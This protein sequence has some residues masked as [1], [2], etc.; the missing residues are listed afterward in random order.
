ADGSG[1]ITCLINTNQAIVAKYLYDPFGNILSQ[2][3]A[4]ADANLYRFASKEYHKNSG[5]IY[6][7]YR[8]YEPNFARWVNRDPLGE[9]GFTTL[10]RH[11]GFRKAHMALR[12][13]EIAQGPNVYAFVGN[14]P[15]NRFDRFGLKYDSE[16]CAGIL[17]EIDFL[18]SLKGRVGI[19]D[20]SVQQQIN[21]LQDEYDENCG[22]DDNDPRPTPPLVPVPVCPV[23][24]P[25][26]N[27]CQKH[28]AIC[29]AGEIAAGTVVVV[30]V[31]ILIFGSGGTSIPVLIGVGA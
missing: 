27:F 17:N 2:S 13:A 10:L 16:E 23:Q 20:N 29:T 14:T 9:V 7:L 6:F 4:L 1:N 5:F 11:R 18:F 22:D 31:G 8:Y 30:G 26:P 3:G 24:Q 12:M 19:D 15:V 21:D 25:Q 28:P